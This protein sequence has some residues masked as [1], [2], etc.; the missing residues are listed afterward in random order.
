MKYVKY[1][2][3][4][5]IHEYW[6][7]IPPRSSCAYI[8]INCCSML[9]SNV[10][11]QTSRSI[12]STLPELLN[13]SRQPN[14]WVCPTP[15][16]RLRYESFTFGMPGS[17]VEFSYEDI[18]CCLN[19]HLSLSFHTLHWCSG[20]WCCMNLSELYVCSK[21]RIRKTLRDA[22]D[23][24]AATPC[25]Y[26]TV[27]LYKT[28]PLGWSHRLVTSPGQWSPKFFFN[29]G[30]GDGKHRQI[31][32]TRKNQLSRSGCRVVV[33]KIVVP[34]LPL[35]AQSESSWNRCPLK[36]TNHLWFNWLNGCVS[37]N[38][39]L[40][41]APV[42][43]YWQIAYLPLTSLQLSGETSWDFTTRSCFSTILLRKPNIMSP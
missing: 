2:V 29:T 4:I 5:Y 16:D 26:I 19:H 28:F 43:L 42:F 1:G 15:S 37:S 20:V 3:Y 18:P 32:A 13:D 24:G 11:K 41:S 35:L 21:E 38:G 8:Q 22:L 12:N 30:L 33:A 9:L 14:R 36:R 31:P 25:M 6:W 7:N 27:T 34:N 39:I 17:S 40:L 10:G 23:P